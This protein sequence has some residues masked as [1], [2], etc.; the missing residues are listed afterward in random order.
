MTSFDSQNAV[1][2]ATILGAF[3]LDSS[4]T[5][6]L[7][8][9]CKSPSCVTQINITKITAKSMLVVKVKWRHHGNILLTIARR[10]IKTSWA[11]YHFQCTWR[12]NLG[13]WRLV[14][15]SSICWGK[16]NEIWTVRRGR[17]NYWN[18][19]TTQTFIVPLV[20]CC[21]QTLPEREMF[22]KLHVS[23]FTESSRKK[24]SLVACHVAFLSAR[25]SVTVLS[26]IVIKSNF[27][28]SP[29]Q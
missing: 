29:S 28:L 3:V 22:F 15:R 2:Q 10:I 9:Y 17:R 7:D 4:C 27:L 5:W 14:R 1:R 20:L 19:V 25:L 18:Y 16:I 11:S 26:R 21:D 13:L 12:E 24:S 23:R 6:D 8:Y